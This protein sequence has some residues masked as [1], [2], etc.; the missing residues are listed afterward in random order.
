MWLTHLSVWIDLL[1]QIHIVH[2][3]TTKQV[4]I[5]NNDK[6]KKKISFKIKLKI[7]RNWGRMDMDI[8]NTHL[9]DHPLFVLK[10]KL[11]PYIILHSYIPSCLSYICQSFK[12]YE[13]T[14]GVIRIRK[15][16]K[17][18]QQN[19]QKKKDKQRSTKYYTKKKIEQHEP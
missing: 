12:K 7:R 9:H 16:K 6:Q 5:N 18:R 15:S 13:Y 2:F 1:K 8:Q 14:K 17:Y 4:F 19:G 11:F 3:H 10:L